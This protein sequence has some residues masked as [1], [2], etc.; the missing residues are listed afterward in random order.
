MSDYAHILQRLKGLQEQF[1]QLVAEV[2][3]TASANEEASNRSVVRVA[4][5]ERRAE[6]MPP[7]GPQ[8]DVILPSTQDDVET[9]LGGQPTSDFPDCCAVGDDQDYYCS[10]TLIAPNLVV[11]A[12]HCEHV[13]QVFLKGNDVRKPRRGETIRI[14]KQFSHDE[15]DL[16]VLLLEINSKVTPRHVAQDNETNASE[17]WLVGFGTVN[18]AGTIGYGLKRMVKV[19]ITSLGCETKDEHEKYGCRQNVEI[20]AGH[21]GLLKDSCR[22]DSG[23]PLYIQSPKG[24]FYLLGATSRGLQSSS[25]PCGDG[26][27]YV[28]VDRFLDWI[29]EQTGVS[30]PGPFS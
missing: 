26:G 14:I 5:T 25:Q 15:A 23:G 12:R 11:T 8:L 6:M 30:I 20:V 29:H 4:A 27:I 28:R 1:D 16:R 13:T 7:S 21:R 10:G 3:E 17:A 24:T 22:G 9:I 18:P 19:P 2:S